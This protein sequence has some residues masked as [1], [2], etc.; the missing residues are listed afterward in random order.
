ME[1]SLKIEKLNKAFGNLDIFRDFNL[2][3]RKGEITS[4]LGP[5]GS[6]KTTLLNLIA[7]LSEADSLGRNDFSDL[8]VSYVFQEPRLLPWKTVSANLEYVLKD[9]YPEWEIKNKIKTYLELVELGDY[10]DYYPGA[11]SGGMK[12]RVSLARAFCF[13]SEIILM[14]EA[15]QSLDPKLKSN[16]IRRFL[17]LWK[18]D[19]RTTLFVTHNIDEAVNVGQN[20]I[21][22]SQK[23]V[24]I[25]KQFK[26]EKGNES[27]IKNE[28]TKL[29]H[30]ETD[31]ASIN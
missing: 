17:E 29:L 14:D 31:G 15:F 24:E 4:L 11:L 20:V 8:V 21:L 28:M 3:I 19:K 27:K 9:H 7:G 22:L 1:E 5:S 25:I 6:G 12:Q 18:Q 2:S 10:A 30:E 13:P 26:V 23:P 16:L